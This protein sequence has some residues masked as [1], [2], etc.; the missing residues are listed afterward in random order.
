LLLFAALATKHA[1][2]D[3]VNEASASVPILELIELKT[4]MARGAISTTVFRRVPVPDFCRRRACAFWRFR[5]LAV[6]AAL[7]ASLI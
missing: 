6:A 7:H 4:D 5:R 3:S 2:C 1:R